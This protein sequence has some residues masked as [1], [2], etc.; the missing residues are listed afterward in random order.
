MKAII[1]GISA[2]AIFV[3]LMVIGSA[4]SP[5]HADTATP[6]PTSEPTPAPIDPNLVDSDFD[7]CTDAEELGHNPSL[8]GK[9]DPSN[10]FDFFDVPAGDPPQ[11]DRQ[12][13]GQD[14]GAIVARFGSTSDDLGELLSDPQPAPAYHTAYD[15]TPKGPNPWN[16]GPPDGGI[17]GQDIAAVVAQFGHYCEGVPA[18][19]LEAIC[20]ELLDEALSDGIEVEDFHCSDDPVPEQVEGQ[21][22]E[23]RRWVEVVPGGTL[24]GQL[25][26]ID[27]VDISVAETEPPEEPLAHVV[28][29]PTFQPRSQ[30]LCGPQL[31]PSPLI[32]CR[33]VRQRT[34]R[35]VTAGG[36]GWTCATLRHRQAWR[37]SNVWPWIGIYAVE[38]P[39]GSISS[40][41]PCQA[42][43]RTTWLNNHAPTWAESG[44]QAEWHA[45]IWTPWGVIPLRTWNPRLKIVFGSKWDQTFWEVGW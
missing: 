8:G 11:R 34:L 45:G 25:A 23:T 29:S 17:F 24:G 3:G 26:L 14:I 30:S 27:S 40:V 18:P 16:S 31:G 43:N 44:S 5:V 42:K 15:R 12:V 41:Y 20:A 7:G 37:V 2:L 19:D 33:V 39:I 10:P 13:F 38:Q 4:P 28:D 1:A 22:G 36:H 32:T 21:V 9:R 6:T 35:L